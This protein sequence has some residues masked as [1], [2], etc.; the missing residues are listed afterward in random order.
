MQ[1][2]KDL[3]VIKDLYLNTRPFPEILIIF[4]L[5]TYLYISYTSPKDIYYNYTGIMYQQGNPAV[6]EA[7]N[8]IIEGKYSKSLFAN[9][10]EFVGT[11]DLGDETVINCHL[12]FNRNHK[13]ALE[14]IADLETSQN[15][16]GLIYTDSIFQEFTIMKFEKAQNGEFLSDGWYI[17]APCTTREEAVQISNRLLRKELGD[18]FFVE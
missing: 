11:I 3:S 17:S 14:D 2:V 15:T 13:A 12:K 6:T 5:L 8:I 9:V 16:Y 18:E 4:F 1:L 7:F 10:D